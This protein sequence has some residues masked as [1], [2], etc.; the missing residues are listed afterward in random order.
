M[1][2]RASTKWRAS[3]SQPAAGDPVNKAGT[4]S[5]KPLDSWRCFTHRARTECGSQLVELGL[6][7]SMIALFALGVVEFGQA[8]YAYHFVSDVARDATRYAMVRGAECKTWTSACPASAGDI[9]SYVQSIVP[10]GIYLNSSAAQTA[11]GYLSVAATWPGNNAGC[12]AAAGAPSNTPGC[13]VSVTV[14]YNYGFALPVLSS[15][16]PIEMTSSSE[17]IIS[18]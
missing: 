5:F 7:V 14:Q 8:L 15:L 18:Q 1:K 3:A 11:P 6:A 10:S 16:N 17:M 9:S 2:K 12:G 4:P 13:E